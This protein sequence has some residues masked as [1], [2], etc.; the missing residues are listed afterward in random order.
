MT[1]HSRFHLINSAKADFS[2]IYASPDPRDY[3]RV[4]GGLDYMIPHLAQPVFEQLVE[5][6]KRFTGRPVTV[7]D[8]GCSYGVNGALLKYPLRFDQ[9][10]ERYAMPAL[11]GL[12]PDA[13]ATLDRNYY[14]AWPTRADVRVV[15]LDVSG[16][17]VRYAERCGAIDQGIVADLEKR[18]LS[19][20]EAHLLATV[21]LVISTGCVGYVTARTFDRIMPQAAGRAAPWVASFVLRMFDYAGIAKS[22]AGYG[23]ATEKFNGATFI[24][25]RFRDGDEMRAT[26]AA[27]S[28]RGLTPRD[29]EA[30]GVFHAELFVSR[31]AA[32][33]A[34]ASI[35]D[36]LSIASGANRPRGRAAAMS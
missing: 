21:D 11:R 23:L 1:S 15:G 5:A 31:P 2:A 14:G 7:L 12:S 16:A 22:L 27:L 34:A 17:A 33:I 25:R 20:D 30:D 26:V 19:P 4:L 13:L 24:Q 10:H 35:N 9:L 28:Q 29:K 36:L 18:D 32:E 6:R 3:F 8:L